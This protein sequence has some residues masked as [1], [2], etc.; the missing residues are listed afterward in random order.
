MSGISPLDSLL[1]HNPLI[2]SQVHSYRW[3][4]ISAYNRIEANQRI[5]WNI[6]GDKPTKMKLNGK[7]KGR[8][9]V[10]KINTS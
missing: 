9:F 8:S 2:L 6:G 5:S 1:R 3:G 7:Y 4:R 10:F